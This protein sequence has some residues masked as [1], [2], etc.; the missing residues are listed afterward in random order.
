MRAAQRRHDVALAVGREHRLEAELGDTLLHPTLADCRIRALAA[1]ERARALRVPRAPLVVAD[2]SRPRRE[3][4][5]AHR[6][7]R[8]G[9]NEDDELAVQAGAGRSALSI[10]ARC[11]FPE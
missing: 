4:R 3:Q 8:G 5:I 7:Q 10:W 9:G 6:V 1:E 2:P 11:S